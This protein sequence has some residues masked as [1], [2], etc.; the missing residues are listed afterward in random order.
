MSRRGLVL[1]ASLSV[2]WGLPYLFI[3][4]AVAELD[5]AVTV[6]LRTLPASVLLLAYG[7]VRGTLRGNLRHW[8]YAVAFAFVE[9]V[10]PWWWVSRAEQEISSGLTGLLLA[11][12]PL[13]GVVIARLRGHRDA[14]SARRLL[15]MAIGSLGVAL[16]VGVDSAELNVSALPVLMVLGAAFGYALG[17]AVISRLDG[18]ADSATLI[19]MSLAVVS[20]VYLPI[21]L[22]RWPETMP[23]AQALWSIVVLTLVCTVAA[24]LTFFALIAEIGPVRATLVT[25]L[26]PAVALLLGLVFA[27][28]PLTLGVALGFPLVLAG[29]YFATRQ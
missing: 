9:M 29:S 4:F 16:L 28:E 23:S 21:V 26:N 2:I 8:R 27:A 14:L 15:G 5:P 17:P 1:F 22:P 3:K 13:F 24:F 19:G 25:Y 18:V 7:A 6:F 20:V 12:V 10:F 11:T